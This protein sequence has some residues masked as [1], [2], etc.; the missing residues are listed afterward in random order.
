MSKRGPILV[1]LG[2][3]TDD[4][5]HASRFAACDAPLV[6][7]TAELMG[8]HMIE[9]ASDHDEL[10]TIA[11]KLP[12]GKIFASGRAFV[13]FVRRAA[14]EKLATLVTAGVT[15]EQRIASG[16]R[17]VYPLADM[18]TTDAINAADTLWA[19]VE[20]GTVVLAAQPELYGPGWW[21]GVVVDVAGDELTIRWID[22]LTLDSFHCTRREVALRHPAAD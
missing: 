12:L 7:R 11:E 1:V 14:F 15:V 21:E 5:P 17:P 10:Y 8:F 22:D 9:V 19:K 16:A 20:V 2:T 18:F 4:K 6:V 3:G 13:P